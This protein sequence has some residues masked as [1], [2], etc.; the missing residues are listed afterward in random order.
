MIGLKL[1]LSRLFKLRS[2]EE[3]GSFIID[4]LVVLNSNIWHKPSPLRDTC[5]SLQ[6]LT[7]LEFVLSM[8]LNAI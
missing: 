3:A 5:V 8:S 2:D 4:F 6:K 1:V 7:A